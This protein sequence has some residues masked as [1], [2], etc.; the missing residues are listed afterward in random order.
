MSIAVKIA[1][2]A[3]LTVKWHPRCQVYYNSFKRERLATICSTYVAFNVDKVTTIR[4][5]ILSP[6][7]Q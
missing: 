4:R 6:A 7:E 3:M 1:M 5:Q 2:A